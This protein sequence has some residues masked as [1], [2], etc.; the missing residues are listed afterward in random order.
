MT[1]HGVSSIMNQITKRRPQPT[2]RKIR[3]KFN[4][5]KAFRKVTVQR[6]A[7]PGNGWGSQSISILTETPID[8]QKPETMSTLFTGVQP[9]FTLIETPAGRAAVVP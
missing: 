8:S 9:P 5:F 1:M 3:L 2:R 7:N 4:A 6:T